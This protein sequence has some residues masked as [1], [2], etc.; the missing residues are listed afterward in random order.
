MPRRRQ[1]PPVK[2]RLRKF[3]RIK[4]EQ[5]ILPV[6]RREPG[7]PHDLTPEAEQRWF[8]AL[9]AG[10]SFTDAATFAGLKYNTVDKWRRRGEGR[11]PK[12]PPTSEYIRFARLTLQAKA[13]VKVMV[14]GN[15][16]KLSQTNVE[17]ATRYL[18][19]EDPS[20]R[21]SALDA[22]VEEES[23]VAVQPVGQTI[24]VDNRIQTVIILQ[25]DELP[26]FVADQ[27]AKRRAAR[28]PALPPPA[29]TEQADVPSRLREAGLR[30]E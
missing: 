3:E 28:P 25:P 30:T 27:L 20:W 11:D 24:E 1:P 10:A 14:L 16:V 5:P 6:E 17:A 8:A 26:D 12:H 22:P 23:V 15:M 19:H 18:A 21:K 9:R 29:L 2:I 13:E 4:R 7:R